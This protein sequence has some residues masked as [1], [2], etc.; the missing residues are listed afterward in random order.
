MNRPLDAATQQPHIAIED[1]QT[2]LDGVRWRYR[3]A[4]S[5][6]AVL[7]VHGLMGYSFS[8]RHT[9][10]VLARQATVYAVDLP[11]AGFSDRPAGMDCSQRASAARLLRFMD[12]VGLASCDLLGTSHGGALAMTVAA[13]APER[14]RSLIL[15]A[16]VNPWS[17]HGKLLSLF[18]T[19][20]PIGPLFLHAMPHL[21]ILHDFYFR[22][23][24]GDTRRIRPGTREGYLAP[25]Q[26]AGSF[27]YVLGVLRSWNRD[28]KELES[29]LPGIAHIPTLLIWG[30]LDAAVNPASAYQ[31][32][33]RF[34]DCHLL[35]MKGVGHLPY[36]ETP[37]EFNRAVTEFL[38]ADNR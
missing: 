9:I 28:L 20:P 37:E 18:L 27:E 19:S 11:G 6:P 17:A 3:R 24:Y 36:E 35:M 38:F 23:L 12:G 16:P 1:L 13:L 32:Q 31:L 14:V 21:Q 34:R 7:L 5:G 2:E 22:R 4:G 29:L 10:P 8:W 33:K 30:S 25:M 15:V 26:R